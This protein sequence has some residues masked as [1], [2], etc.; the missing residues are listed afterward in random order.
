MQVARFLAS[1]GFGHVVNIEGGID[2]W[3]A[4]VD[5]TIARY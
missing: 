4:Q 2:A 5:S 1:N 3:S